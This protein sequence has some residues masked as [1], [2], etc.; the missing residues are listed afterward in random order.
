[1]TNEERRIVVDMFKSR[2]LVALLG[3]NV[4]GRGLDV[5]AKVLVRLNPRSSMQLT[6]QEIGRI[7]RAVS[8][9][10]DYGNSSSESLVVIDVLTPDW[11]GHVTADAAFA[12]EGLDPATVQGL[13]GELPLFERLRQSNGV[14]K[15]KLQRFWGK[16]LSTI[17]ASFIK[18]FPENE[19]CI[20]LVQLRQYLRSLD[21]WDSTLTV[22][23]TLNESDLAYVQSAL[24]STLQAVQLEDD[25]E[26]LTY[27]DVSTYHNLAPY[28]EVMEG[29]MEIV[30]SFLDQE[31]D[32][33]IEFLVQ[34]PV[35]QINTLPE[36]QSFFHVIVWRSYLTASDIIEEDQEFFV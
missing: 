17:Y 36:A 29:L 34:K 8:I 32:L 16:S 1:M 4:I 30:D 21:G 28:A 35:L 31:S 25:P 7:N 33:A 2:Q 3:S 24:I 19:S 18:D 14:L 11:E 27:S 23:D 13:L 6:I 26:W 10:T 20:S 15:P 22:S 9:N 5:R 12:F